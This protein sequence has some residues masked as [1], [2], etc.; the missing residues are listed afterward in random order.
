LRAHIESSNQ[1]EA[2]YSVACHFTSRFPCRID[3]IVGRDEQKAR[4]FAMVGVDAS[5]AHQ[6]EAVWS[7]VAQFNAE[8]RD[9]FP[10]L[11]RA[12]PCFGDQTRRKPMRDYPLQTGEW[13]RGSVI[14][15]KRQCRECGISIYTTEA[16]RAVQNTLLKR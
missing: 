14:I 11:N 7:G 13:Q 9:D 4:F 3:Y 16:V 8:S 5:D 10:V 6:T 1:R 2:P 12:L 15:R